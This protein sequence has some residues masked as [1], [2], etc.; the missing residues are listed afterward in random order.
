MAELMEFTGYPAERV[1]HLW[2]VSKKELARNWQSAAIP[3]DDRERLAQWYRENSELY[4]FEI[5]AYNLEYKR[6]RSNLK[7]LRMGRG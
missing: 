6:I 1:T 7:V 5:S 2:A 3:E 4:L